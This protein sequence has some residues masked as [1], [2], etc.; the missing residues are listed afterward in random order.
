V[1]PKPRSCQGCPAYTHGRGFVPPTAPD[2]PPR[3]AFVGQGPGE[4]EA[5]FSEPFYYRAPAGA[6][7]RDWIDQAGIDI[8]DTTLGNAVQC[9]LPQTLVRGGLGRKS[10]EPT[11]AEAAHCYRAHVHPWLAALPPA[12]HIVTVGAVATRLLLNQRGSVATLNGVTHQATLPI[13]KETP[14]ELQPTQATPGKAPS[15]D[16]TP[17][18]VHPS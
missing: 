10:R 6:M 16:A 11:P 1:N 18:G 15:H 8:R 4:Q 9:W 17:P 7:L 5:I 13:P 14:R 3:F 2:R 12:T